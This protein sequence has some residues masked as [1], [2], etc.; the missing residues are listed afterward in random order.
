M[1]PN[2][3]ELTLVARRTVFVPATTAI[4]RRL[5]TRRREGEEASTVAGEDIGG[6]LRE[7]KRQKSPSTL[8]TPHRETSV[9]GS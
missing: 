6:C 1:P 9:N 8:E 7:A 4:A 2:E 3:N 5:R